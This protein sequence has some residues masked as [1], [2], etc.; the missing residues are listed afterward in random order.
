MSFLNYLK[1]FLIT[2][3]IFFIIDMLWLGLI[4]KNF[5]QKHLGF[6]MGNVNWA[7]SI[8]FYLIFI[9]GLVVF[10]IAPNL[11]E[12]SF[13]KILFMS[14]LFGFV[15][16]ATYDL[17]NQATI[18]DWPLIVTIID[19]MWGTLLAVLVSMISLFFSRLII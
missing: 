17:T 3:P 1:V 18:K 10:V 9:V 16:Y 19:L 11:H 4:A 2:L 13:I 5:Y 15:T 12:Q 8:I 7:A 14:A 6:L